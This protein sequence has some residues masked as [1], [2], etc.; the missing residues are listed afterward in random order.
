MRAGVL[1]YAPAGGHKQHQLWRSCAYITSTAPPSASLCP[2][3]YGSRCM[4]RTLCW[5]S[6]STQP[7]AFSSQPSRAPQQTMA[8]TH[9]PA[10]RRI[11]PATLQ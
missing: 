6:R 10:L 11:A 9:K 1:E 7:A 8:D 4:V 5:P 3:S 2:V